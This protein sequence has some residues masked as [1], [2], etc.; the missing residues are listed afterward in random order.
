MA[1]SSQKSSQKGGQKISERQ[2]HILKLIQANPSISRSELSKKL[3]IQPSAVQ[4][5]I[6]KLK[7]LEIIKRIGLHKSGHWEVIE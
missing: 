4:K 6:E 1:D 7:C 3:N 2:E 5:H